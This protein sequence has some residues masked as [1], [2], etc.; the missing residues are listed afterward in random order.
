MAGL[1]VAFAAVAALT[2]CGA[3]GGLTGAVAG[4]ASGAATSNPAV[5]VAIG[6]GVQAGVDESV[7][8]AMRYLSREEQDRIAALVGEMAVGERRPWEVRHSVP[9]GNK[10]GE[11]TVVRAFATPLAACKEAAFSVEDIDAE[12]TDAPRPRFVTTACQ[13][14]NGWKWA[15]AE[16]AVPRWGALQ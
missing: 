13:G 9:Y 16:P 3:A 7:K 6:I 1:L 14:A 2:A 4:L 5:G 8:A 11:V 12:P 10:Q 15:I